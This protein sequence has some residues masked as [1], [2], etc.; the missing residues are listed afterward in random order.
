MTGAK[1]GLERVPQMADPTRVL[2]V[3]DSFNFGG[4][5]NLIA[6]LGRHAPAGLVLSVASLAPADSDRNAMLD[7]LTGAGLNP[8]YL[9]VRRLL[10][11]K[12]F[13]RLVCALRRASVD[14]IH[15]HLGY[16]A[17]LVTL[18]A[19]LAGKPVVA[20]LHLSPQPHTGCGEWL[21]ERLSVR[22][23]GRLGR[24]VLVSQHA[25]DEYERAHGP[26]RTTWRM[27]SNAVD[28]DRYT[29]RSESRP[30]DRP[31][32]AVIAALRPDKN[33]ADLLR[34]WSGVVAVHPGAKLL[35]VGDGPSR[36][37]IESAVAAAGL[38]DSVQLLGR[39]EDVPEILQTVDGVVSASVD[40]ALPTA[41]IEAGA[42][43]LPVVASDAG[44]TREIV[45][46]GVTGRLVPI[47]D[48]PALTEALLDTIGNPARAAAFGAAGRARV[49][50][51]YSMPKWVD[52]LTALYRE[53]MDD[54][55]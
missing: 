4:A 43:G 8:T 25:F 14:V 50:E 34:A 20:T 17:I 37:D 3:L 28:L 26:A 12:G 49:E 44:G 6:E 29:V 41:L 31:V 27:I 33:H 53:V 39:R 16:S 22:I 45:V 36:P 52:R 30:A 21:K 23:P 40:E 48:V 46:D 15:A 5:E 35:V 9:S 2:M 11:P 47:R 1:G 18:A 42:C 54:R 10:D 19:R 32:W 7:R 38:A 51:K 24:L 13:F 55:S